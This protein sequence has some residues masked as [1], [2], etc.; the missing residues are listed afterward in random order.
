MQPCLAGSRMYYFDFLHV[1]K[2]RSGLE[3][4]LSR[5]QSH[6]WSIDTVK[7]DDLLWHH[8][9]TI[10]AHVSGENSFVI[11]NY[12]PQLSL[13]VYVTLDMSPLKACQIHWPVQVTGQAAQPD[14]LGECCSLCPCFHP[15]EK[16]K[17]EKDASVSIHISLSVPLYLILLCYYSPPEDLKIP[18]L[19]L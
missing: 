8:Q 16:K 5:G 14:V 1:V 4:L 17:S 3:S 12:W 9:C 19:T 15:L 10:A 13:N 18:V 11:W 7:M 6:V 2:Q